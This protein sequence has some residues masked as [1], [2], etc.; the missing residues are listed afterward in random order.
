MRRIQRTFDNLKQRGGK[1]LVA[2]ITAGHPDLEITQKLIIA[3]EKAGVDIVEIGVPFSDPTADGPV[4]Q[5]SSQKALKGGA[6]LSNIL[7]MI[8]SLRDRCSIPLVLF[9]Y[10]NPIY[11]YGNEL[12]AQQAKKAGIDG[13]LVVDLPPEEAKELRQ[14]TDSL[15]IDFISLIAPTTPEARIQKIA[16]RATGFL[17]YISITGVTGTEKPVLECVKPH[18][19]NIRKITA[20]PLVVGFGI[21]SPEQAKDI[22]S[23]ADGVVVGSALVKLIDEYSGRDKLIDRV[24]DYIHRMRCAI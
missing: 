2:Y 8:E 23:F 5:M 16:A 19:E 6:T 3:L 21:T 12:F 1:A 10:Y 11:A 9:G 20:L 14:F 24:S 22:A 18:V 17:Y 4:I 7:T 15:K 13:I